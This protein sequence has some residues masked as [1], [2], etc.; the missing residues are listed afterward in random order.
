MNLE[1]K[2]MKMQSTKSALKPTLKKSIY[3]LNTKLS[4]LRKLYYAFPM[5]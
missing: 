1:N 5:N 3:L 4:P 2:L